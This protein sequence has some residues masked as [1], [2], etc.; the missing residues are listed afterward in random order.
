M[1]KATQLAETEIDRLRAKLRQSSDRERTSELRDGKENVWKTVKNY[2][3]IIEQ[4]IGAH[5]ATREQCGQYAT[6][7]GPYLP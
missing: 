1:K 4:G 3:G 5:R 2:P 6:P 7:S